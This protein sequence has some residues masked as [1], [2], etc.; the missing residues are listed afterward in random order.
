MLL[1]RSEKTEQCFYS[2]SSQIR[3]ERN[4]YYN[5]L[6]QCQKGDVDISL[7]IEWYLHCLKRAIAASEET[8]EAVLMRAH[9]WETHTGAIFNKRQRAIIDRLL[10]KFEGKLTSSKWEKL[11]KCSQDTA[12]RDINDLLQRH[13]LIKEEADGRS[14]SYQLNVAT[15][16]TLVQRK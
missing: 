10:D 1:A 6:E 5:I 8:L 4:T 2:M 16:A 15:I 11:T 14:T 9:F 12:L 7:W 3:R 13:I